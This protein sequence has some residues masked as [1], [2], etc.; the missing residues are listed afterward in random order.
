MEIAFGGTGGDGRFERVAAKK[1]K[2]GISPKRATSA[3]K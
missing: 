2:D 3:N 1:L